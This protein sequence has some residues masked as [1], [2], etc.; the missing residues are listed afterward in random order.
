MSASLVG[1]EMCI[2]DSPPLPPS[3]I[4][5]PSAF[6][7]PCPLPNQAV[8]D[9]CTMGPLDHMCPQMTFGGE[10]E[11]ELTEDFQ[12][13]QACV[14]ELLTRGCARKSVIGAGVVSVVGVG[15][16]NEEL[17]IGRLGS[18]G[19]LRGVEGC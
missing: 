16:W 19:V 10:R 6:P 9:T 14:D 5:L 18:W 17:G 7:Q 12:E 8:A 3:S 15:V 13:G 11:R 2:R 1:S 4:V